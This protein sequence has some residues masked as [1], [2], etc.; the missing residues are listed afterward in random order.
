[1]SMRQSARTAVFTF[2]TVAFVSCG[3]AIFA[4]SNASLE[5]RVKKVMDRPEFAHSRFGIK[6]ISAETGDVVYELNSQQL[7]VPGSTTK[8]LSAGTALELLGADYRFHTKIYRTGSIQENGTLKGDLVLV[9]AGDLN[10]SNRIQPDGTLAFEDHDHSY[11]GPDSKGLSGDPLQ[12]MR[13]F[14]R[15]VAATG[16][17]RIKGRV[18]VDATLFP[19]G[20]RELGTSVVISPIVVNDNVVDVIATPGPNEGSPV[21]LKIAPQTA[22]LTITNQATTGKA[23]SKTSLKYENE[24]SNPDGTRSATLTGSLALASQPVM[25]S[26]PV[27][28]PSRFAATVLME[29]LK[30]QGVT[31]TLP[32]PAD[33]VD[34][35]ALGANYTAEN[36]VAEH[37]SPPLKEEVKVTL[38]VSQNLH[39]SSM[40]FLLGALLAHKDEKIDQ[41]GFEMENAFLTKAGLDLGGAAQSDGA[42]GNAYFSPDFMTRYLLYMS[43]QRG[44]DDFYRSLPILGRDGTLVKIQV[45]SPAAGHVHAKTGTY[46]VYDA[47]NKKLMVTGKG[48]AGYMDTASGQHLILALYVNM[49]SVSMDDPEATQKVAGEALGEIASAAYD[50]PLPSKPGHFTTNEY[51]VLIKSG[52]IVDGSG[53]P[54]VSGDIAIRGDRIA[55]I[56]RLDGVQAKR[57]IDAKGLVV[58]PG[59]IDML[60][61]SEAN[62]LIDNRSLSKLAQ[63]ITTEITGEGGS[64]APQTD[65]TLAPLRPVL[66]HY[67]LKVDWS[68]LDGYFKRLEQ[69]GTPLN[70]GTYVGA[71]QVRQAVLGDVDRAPTPAETDK[72]KALVDQAMRDGALGLST[73][74][75]YPPGHYATTDEL[76]ELAKVAARY[77]GIYGT[78]MRSEGQTEPQAVEEALRIGREANL[79]VEIF[80]LKVSGKTR[81]GNMPKIVKQIQTAR[82]SGQDVTAN[83]YP[84]TAGGTALA[85]SLPPWVADGGLEKLLLRLHDPATRAKIKADMASD[86]PEWENIFFDSGNGSGVMVSGVENSDLKKFDGKTIAQIAAAQNKSQLDALFDFIIADKGQT[87][88]LYFMANESDLMYGLKQPWTSLCLDAGELSLD[89]P[90]FEPHTHPR[91]FGAMPRFLGH[92]VRDLHLLPLEQGIRKMTS[93]PAQ[94]ERL[95]DRGLL[96]EGYF[97]DITIFDPASLKDVA[98]YTEPARLANGVRYVF[99]NGQLEFEDGKLTGRTAGQVLR[100]PGWKQ[101][102]IE[103]R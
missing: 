79:P 84:Y 34:F 78:H 7:F 5:Q 23:G 14:A 29:T 8:L 72:M 27:P 12:V 61:Q 76:I 43:K 46:G 28:E 9:A 47:L 58:S 87:G 73:A 69:T 57:V 45:N 95:L 66:E 98:T 68:T 59:F 82:D 33:Q 18:L 38:K 32:A 50:A 81:W 21:Q 11:G 53:N 6:F 41:A 56:G 74:L 91:A 80:H 35:K 30:E 17:K 60:G 94:R 39:A 25:V 97:A 55:A 70:I 93:L 77:G 44:Y 62:L 24:K 102:A 4:Q 71:G 49:V 22:Y 51:D 15:Q 48:L 64:I 65:L 3:D 16:I 83:M 1:M 54:W 103:R 10:L 96:R 20:E 89:G 101:A 75:I 36:M 88:A 90:L 85:S 86:H 40:P 19:E 100:G 37:V 31:S 99:V 67:K 92:Y 52:S 26:Y 13:E 42:G 63:G 2:L